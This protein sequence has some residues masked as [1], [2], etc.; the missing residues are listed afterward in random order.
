MIPDLASGLAHHTPRLELAAACAGL[1]LHRSGKRKILAERAA[2]WVSAAAE[3]GERRQRTATLMSHFPAATLRELSGYGLV[4]PRGLRK[5]ALAQA[6]AERFV[7]EPEE[8]LNALG[9]EVIELA[10]EGAFGSVYKVRRPSHCGKLWAAKVVAGDARMHAQEAANLARLWH[11]NI[12]QYFNDFSGPVPIIVTEWCGGGT[13]SGKIGND[14]IHK[15]FTIAHVAHEV[16]DAL[17]YLHKK[18]VYHRDLHPGNVLF[19]RNGE[20]VVADFGLS[21]RD[22]ARPR[23]R[24]YNYRLGDPANARDGAY[25]MFMLGRMLVSMRKG[26]IDAWCQSDVPSPKEFRGFWGLVRAALDAK[27]CNRPTAA[28]FA[29]AI[30][31]EFELEQLV[32]GKRRLIAATTA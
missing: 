22:G 12:L 9:F 27:P 10:G 26:E 16:C 5:A 11:A 13:L 18:G 2:G 21:R 20:L 30:V 3:V 4:K 7:P 17:A 19:R 23:V 28:E 15:T 29:K 31:Q 6:L 32:K 1:G 14:E 8:A 25:D 24:H